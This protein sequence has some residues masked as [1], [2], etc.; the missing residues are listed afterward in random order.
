VR[1]SPRCAPAPGPP[2]LA[3]SV[4]FEDWHQL[5]RRRLGVHAWDRPS[6]ALAR[7]CA[8]LLDTLERLGLRATFFVLGLAAR[9]HPELV[10]EIAARGHEIASHGFAHR[11]IFEISP[12]ELRSDLEA[13]IELIGELTGIRPLGYR[14]P[15]FSINRATPFALEILAELGFAYDSSRY[16]S[17]RIPQRLRPVPPGPFRIEL[18]SGRSLWELPVAVWRRPPLALPVGGGSYWQLVPTA[19]LLRLLLGSARAGTSAL[20][21]HPN[22]C[23][24]EPLRTGVGRGEPAGRRVRARLREL[25]RNAG[26]GR[27]LRHLRAA[28]GRLELV[29]CEEALRRHDPE[30]HA[31]AGERVQAWAAQ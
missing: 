18:G 8:V 19:P 25:R 4:D 14:A 10:R 24:P 11:R 26:R 23:D 5:A 9:R 6:P 1:D 3:L 21:L 31:S 13:S 15:A 22:E 28:A 29:P 27:T 2:A 7:Q 30:L 17:P 20:Y 12:A 16:D